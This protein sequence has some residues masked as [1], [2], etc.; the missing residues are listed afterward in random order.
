MEEG[1]FRI[2]LWRREVVPFGICGT[3]LDGTYF[4]LE[5]EEGAGI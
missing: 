5:S 4:V 3:I 1:E 2:K